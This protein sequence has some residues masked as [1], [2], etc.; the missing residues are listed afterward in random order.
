[1]LRCVLRLQRWALAIQHRNS[2][3]GSAPAQFAF[4][5]FAAQV[6]SGAPRGRSLKTAKIAKISKIAK[7]EKRERITHRVAFESWFT[8][9]PEFLLTATSSRS[10]R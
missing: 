3:P 9:E 5:Y 2:L 4:N 7:G 6:R 1:V 10:R 8:P